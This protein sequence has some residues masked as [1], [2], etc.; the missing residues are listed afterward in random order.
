M[1]S[2]IF[3]AGSRREMHKHT[4]FIMMHEG[5]S[6]AIGRADVMISTAEY[7]EKINNNMSQLYADCGNETAA[8][9]PREDEK[10]SRVL[11]YRRR[12]A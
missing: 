5:M 7:L 8:Q 6:A 9:I 4:S 2:V 12:S 3:C 1:G 10:K 11:V